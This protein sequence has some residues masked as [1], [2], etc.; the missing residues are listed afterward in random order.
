MRTALPI[1]VLL[2]VC[3]ALPISASAKQPRSASAKRKF[4]LT[5]PCPSTGRTRGTCPGYTK[6]PLCRLRAEGLTSLQ[7]CNGK[8]GRTRRRR[9][10]GRLKAAVGEVSL[11]PGRVHQRS[12]FKGV[13]RTTSAC[14]LSDGGC[15]PDSSRSRGSD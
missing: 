5:H 12:V 9:I 7:T 8:P 4:Q 14:S 13:K 2:A 11:S 3:V 1:C 6:G 10:S 15:A